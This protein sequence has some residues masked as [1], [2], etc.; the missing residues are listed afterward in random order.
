MSART[1]PPTVA[2]LLDADDSQKSYLG[3]DDDG[4]ADIEIETM[5]MTL[6]PQ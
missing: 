2:G 6:G 4:T 3:H 1:D 5:S